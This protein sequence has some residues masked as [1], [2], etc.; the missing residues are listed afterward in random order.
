MKLIILAISLLLL[1]GCVFSGNSY[2]VRWWNGNLP[3][4]ENERKIWSYC[5]KESESKYSD[6]IDPTETKRMEYRKKCMKNGG[7]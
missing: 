5:L 2:F 6:S 3:M 1:S 4:P 7:K